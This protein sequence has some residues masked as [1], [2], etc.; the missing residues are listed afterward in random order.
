MIIVKLI[1]GLGN[2][3]F[4]YA[5]GRSL[6]ITNNIDFKL[7]IT[8]FKNT[9]KLRQYGL[10]KFNIVENIATREEIA[11]FKKPGGIKKYSRLFDPFKPYY[12][13]RLINEQSYPFDQN[14]L[15]VHHDAYIEGHWASERYFNSI[16]DIIRTDFSVKEQPDEIN[17]SIADEIVHTESVSI[18]IR[19]G[20]YVSDPL[21]LKIHGLCS[22]DYYHRAVE[23]IA[24]KIREPHF[25]IFSNDHAWVEK[26]LTIPYPMK[27][28][29]IN[30]SEKDYEDIRLMSLCKH[31]IIANSTFSWWGAWLSKNAEKQIYSPKRWY[32]VDYDIKDLL[33]ESWIKL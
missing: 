22:L 31:H 3:M 2:Q 18:H 1:G 29:S 8:S 9:Y 25:F 4:Q 30:G 15:K 23:D 5:L 19:R 10:D 16:K 28:V 20:D 24:K 6:S 33:P 27:L 17:A 14:I 32:N 21:T 11:E 13:R 12:K 26:N 7:D